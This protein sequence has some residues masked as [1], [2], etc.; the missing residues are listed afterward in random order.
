M[1]KCLLLLVVCFVWLPFM[2]R[3]QIITTYAGGG[4][5]GDGAQATAAAIDDPNDIVFDRYGNLYFTEQLAHCVR[6]IDNSGII[7]TIAGTGTA[8]FGGDW[9]P[10]TAAQLNQP[11]GM[12]IDS[13][14]NL[15]IADAANNRVRKIN[16]STG[17]ITTIA[18]NLSGIGG[19]A[20]GYGG[21]GGMASASLLNLPTDVCFDYVGNLYIADAANYRVRKINTSGIISTIAGNGTLGS[22]GNNGPATVG[23]C[24]PGTLDCDE[25]G[26]LYIGEYIYALIRVMD[27]FGNI[28]AF[29]G[30]SS[31]YIYNGDEIPASSAHIN[32]GS[33]TVKHGALYFG[34]VTNNRIRMIDKNRII[35]TVAGNG[36]DGDDGDGGLATA[37][38]IT[39][40]HCVMFDSC[41]NLYFSQ[42]DSPKI[43]KVTYPYCG[44]LDV[45]GVNSPTK[46]IIYP[47]PVNSV[48]YVECETVMH[49]VAIINI[50][51][52]AVIKSEGG[53]RLCLWGS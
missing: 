43:R 35:H 1:K 27:T 16:K 42:V 25:R 19:G 33:I 15:F 50:L 36:I 45:P 26:N 37:A 39:H 52:Q 12:A 5:G 38:K 48:L 7:S 32:P 47:N 24:T 30:D 8:G 44:Y 22:S 6:K 28:H 21:D 20:G 49:S 10:A 3:G 2:G 23:K 31:F 4:S 29:A 40:P 11:T 46:A 53:E 51:G 9:G 13:S 17:V 14:G 34:D 18:G 41:D